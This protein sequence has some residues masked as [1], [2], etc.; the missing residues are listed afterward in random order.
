VRDQDSA[1]KGQEP[2]AVIGFGASVAAEGGGAAATQVS[3]DGSVHV[4]ASVCGNER[5]GRG[6]AQQP[7][8]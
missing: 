6:T 7:R 4:P 2:E 3:L 1:D 5:V 8:V